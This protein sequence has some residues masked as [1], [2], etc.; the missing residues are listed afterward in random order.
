MT[1]SCSTT[2]ILSLRQGGCGCLC[3]SN[4]GIEEEDYFVERQDEE[5]KEIYLRDAIRWPTLTP[6]ILSSELFFAIIHFED[7]YHKG[8][9]SFISRLWSLLNSH[10]KTI[11]VAALPVW[12]K[13]I[14]KWALLDT[15]QGGLEW[16]SQRL[17]ECQLLVSLLNIR[18][19]KKY[20]IAEWLFTTILLF[21][22]R[23]TILVNYNGATNEETFEGNFEVISWMIFSHIVRHCLWF[24]I[25]F[26]N[27]EKASSNNF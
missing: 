26:W 22:I 4:G 18:W 19:M 13:E 21:A 24:D 8:S 2:G 9:L 3:C 7:S 6:I 12:S 23:M 17:F 25:K 15:C 14:R 10:H 11:D 16:K 5:A 27:F 20:V 1:K